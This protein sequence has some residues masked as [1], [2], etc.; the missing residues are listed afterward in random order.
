MSWD[1]TQAKLR[2][3]IEADD[4]GKDNQI[5]TAM[6]AAL[7]LAE[8]YCDRFF[9]QR[10][11]TTN[12]YHTKTATFQLKRFPITMVTKGAEAATVHHV[13]GIIEFDNTIISK[14]ITFEY[15]GGFVELPADLE[16]AFW[17]IFDNFYSQA[18]GGVSKAVR[19]LQITGVGSIDYGAGGTGSSGS[20]VPEDLMTASSKSILDLYRLPG[21]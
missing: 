11:E 6:D 1:I 21:V 10:S 9:F 12:F 7:A 19:K 15:V 13:A 3:G 16:L 14:K 5:T 4:T 8:K 18:T 2:L 20:G 17:G